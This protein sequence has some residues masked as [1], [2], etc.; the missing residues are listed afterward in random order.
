MALVA[1]DIG[2][3]VV[4]KDPVAALRI[5]EI[6]TTERPNERARFVDMTLS[7]TGMQLSRS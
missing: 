3:I 6:L 2:Q 4:A 7:H 5:R 1:H